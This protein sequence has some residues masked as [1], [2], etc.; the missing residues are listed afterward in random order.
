MA[1]FLNFK[2]DY[3]GLTESKA[4]DNLEMYGNNIF[5]ETE[6]K[7]FKAYHY[8]LD[9]TAVLLLIAGLIQIFA[10]SRYV[11][12]IT[13]TAMAIAQAVTLCI[14]CRKSNDTIRN[15]TLSAKM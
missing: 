2:G 11:T 7:S 14:I 9:P 5:T 1:Q 12:G 8:L 10:L 4:S 6:D 3:K 15:R 13:C